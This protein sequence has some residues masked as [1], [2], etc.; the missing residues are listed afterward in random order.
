VKRKIE[1]AELQQARRM[2][3]AAWKEYPG[4]YDQRSWELWVVKLLR[5]LPA[6][7]VEMKLL[8]LLA[9]RTT[10]RVLRKKSTERKEQVQRVLATLL[11]RGAGR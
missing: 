1:P 4:A 3:R 6:E 8:A 2:L 10:R 9:K 5:T 11:R 7:R